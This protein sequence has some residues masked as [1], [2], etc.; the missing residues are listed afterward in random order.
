MPDY[1]FAEPNLGIKQLH[2][3][4]ML[5]NPSV[6]Q[7]GY[8]HCS[9]FHGRASVIAA[10]AIIASAVFMVSAMLSC[11]GGEAHQFA[12]NFWNERLTNCNGSYYTWEKSWRFVVLYQYKDPSIWVSSYEISDSDRMN[13]YDWRAATEISSSSYRSRS[14]AIQG[15]TNDYRTLQFGPWSQWED[16]DAQKLNQWML[17]SRAYLIWKQNDVSYYKLNFN[18]YPTQLNLPTHVDC[19]L[20]K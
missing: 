4:G 7:H 17:D 10:A 18:V 1:K 8:G 15:G 20:V 2:N 9:W 12:T 5:S 16:G 14:S 11:K 19:S 3:T 6:S 13:G